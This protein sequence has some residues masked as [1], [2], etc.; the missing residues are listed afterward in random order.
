MRR[1]RN[2]KGTNSQPG[3]RWSHIADDGQDF[4]APGVRRSFPRHEVGLTMRLD[5]L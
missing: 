1:W 2:D 4:T 5:L 3:D